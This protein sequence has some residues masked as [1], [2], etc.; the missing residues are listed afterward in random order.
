[1]TKLRHLLASLTLALLPL[2]AAPAARAADAY[3]IRGVEVDVTSANVNAAKDLAVAEAQARAFRLVLERLTAPADHARL[4]KADASQYVRDFAIEQERGSSVRYIAKVAVRFS[5]SAV[6]KL[7][8]DAG[9]PFAEARARP[10]VVVPVWKSSMGKLML[11]D[12]PNPWRAAWNELGGGGLVGIVVPG[13]DLADLS[14]MTPEQALA[15]DPE[16]LRALGE[17]YQTG[18]VLV[19]AAAFSGGGRQLDVS[20]SGTPGLPRPSDTLSY[21]VAEGESEAQVLSRA[22]SDI[23]RAMDTV[24]KQPNLLQFDRAGTL[25]AIVPL[26]GLEDWL[27]VRERLGRVSQVRRYEVVSLSKE[28][29][30]VVLHIVG[31]QEQVKGALGNAGLQLSWGDGFWTMKP[32]GTRR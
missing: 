25:S 11:W 24:Y 26:G 1:M 29:A 19:A 5:P 3:A 9:I 22:A 32:V 28:E 15:A 21:P 20:L 13:G 8:R 6:K 4:P 2:L 18:D 12:E 16:R 14:S 23:Q 30:A 27:A 10:V 17:R 31:D 7:L